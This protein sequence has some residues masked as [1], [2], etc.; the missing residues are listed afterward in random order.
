MAENFKKDI[1]STYAVGGAEAPAQPT[2]EAANKKIPFQPLEGKLDEAEVALK[3]FGKREFTIPFTKLTGELLLS[4][5]EWSPA[6]LTALE[7]VV[8]EMTVVQ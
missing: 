1:L 6:E 5:A 2:E 3:G 8:A 7:P 4:V